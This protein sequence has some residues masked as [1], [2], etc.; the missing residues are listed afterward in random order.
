MAYNLWFLHNHIAANFLDIILTANVM[1]VLVRLESAKAQPYQMEYHYHLQGFIYG[2][3]RD[4]IFD[5][6]HDKEGYK[7]FCFSNIFPAS[8]LKHGNIR[9]LLISSPDRDFVRHISS[10]LQEKKRSGEKVSVGSMEF[11]VKKVETLQISLKVPFTLITGTPIVVRVPREKYE[12]FDVKTR[13]PYEYLYWRQE[14]P[15]E[16]FVDQLEDNLRKK[17]VEFIGKDAGNEPIIQKLKFKKQ[18]A[19]KLYIRGSQQTV[20]GS[21]WEFSFTDSVQEH[22]IQFGY[23]VGFGERNPLGFGFLN[24]KQ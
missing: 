16:M 13:Y 12:K 8:V 21:L 1:R 4:S 24:T 7:F 17:Y 5:H 15:L 14:H 11:N 22:L 19:T 6:V 20:I 3:L 9:H 2:L 23:D 18:V 10:R